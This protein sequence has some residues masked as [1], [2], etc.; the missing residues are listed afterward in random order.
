MC[1]LVYV[2]QHLPSEAHQCPR[3][4]GQRQTQSTHSVSFRP[5]APLEEALQ[6]WQAPSSQLHRDPALPLCRGNQGL[7]SSSHCPQVT[8]LA[9]GGNRTQD[10]LLSSP[11][12]FTTGAAF[13][14]A[15][16]GVGWRGRGPPC[17]PLPLQPHPSP[18]WPAVGTA[19]GSA[20]ENQLPTEPSTAK[21]TDILPTART[22]SAP[23]PS[24][25]PPP[26]GL[27]VKTAEGRSPLGRGPY[28]RGSE[29]GFFPIPFI[30]S[31]HPY[32]ITQGCSTI[33]TPTLLLPWGSRVG[34]GKKFQSVELG[35]GLE[36]N[37][38]DSGK[39][40]PWLLNPVAHWSSTLGWAGLGCGAF[41]GGLLARP[42][43]PGR[44]IEKQEPGTDEF[45]GPCS[46]LPLSLP[47]AGCHRWSQNLS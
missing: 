20:R 19:V 21:A 3:S 18:C 11:P 2:S 5:A 8:P 43:P 9:R 41:S 33:P 35:V 14:K 16:S 1:S 46:P 38:R 12:S 25:P 13:L 42:G 28:Q 29:A 17:V 30:T 36:G 39:G 44:Q 10:H 4:V 32:F 37:R 26:Q 22:P 27:P 45:G 47:H 40:F 31:P 34:E 24:P 6:E 23:R 7:Q 15:G